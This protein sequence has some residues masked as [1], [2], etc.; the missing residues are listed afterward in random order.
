MGTGG[1]IRGVIDEVDSSVIITWVKPR[2]LDTDRILLLKSRIENWAERAQ[3]LLI[4][5]K[6]SSPELIIA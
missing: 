3:K 5:M 4:Q 1:L 6:E 2:I